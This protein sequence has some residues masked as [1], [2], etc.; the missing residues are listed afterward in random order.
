MFSNEALNIMGRE[1]DSMTNLEPV[2]LTS[3]HYELA[4]RDLL[5]DKQAGQLQRQ[6]GS[7]GRLR[8]DS[9]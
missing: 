3:R 6:L 2:D 4:M 9:T 8:G 7:D 5:G 1:I